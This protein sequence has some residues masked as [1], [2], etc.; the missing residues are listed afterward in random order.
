[1]TDLTPGALVIPEWLLR[2]GVGPLARLVWAHIAMRQGRGDKAWPSVADIAQTQGIA[3][4]T[5]R[6]CIAQLEDAGLLTVER[7]KGRGNVYSVTR[8]GMDL[9]TAPTVR[10]SKGEVRETAPTQVTE[11]APL[12]SES[13]GSGQRDRGCGQRDL[14]NPSNNPSKNPPTEPFACAREE[15]VREDPTHPDDRQRAL[16]AMFKREVDQRLGV[17]P[18]ARSMPPAQVRELGMWLGEVAESRQV[19]WGRAA[20]DMLDAW[21][22]DDWVAKQ[23]YPFAHLAKHAAR[24]AE[25]PRQYQGGDILPGGQLAGSPGHVHERALAEFV[26]PDW[27]RDEVAE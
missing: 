26:E 12:D 15:V 10:K 18:T 27:M 20:L 14:R 9:E 2:S 11:T 4:K 17:P 7:Q 6:R 5:V 19:T 25:G 21:F 16:R 22:A 8:L 1:M 24:Y 13:I 3:E 23:R